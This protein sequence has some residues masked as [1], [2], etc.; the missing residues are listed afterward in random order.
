MTSGFLVLLPPSETK[1]DGG[2]SAFGVDAPGAATGS[3]PV[4]AGSGD[5]AWP[6]LDGIRSDLIDDLAALAHDVSATASALKISPK[7][8]EIEAARNRE[9]R[10]SPRMPAGLRYTGVLYDALDASSLDD[11]SWRWMRR[12]VAVHSALYGLVGAGEPIAAY[13]CSSSSRV[14][15][16]PLKQRWS[17]NIADALAA[18]DGT[19]LDLRSGGYQSLGSAGAKALM[20]DVVTDDGD[21]GVRALNH[22]NKRA[23]GELVRA[24]ATSEIGRSISSSAGGADVVRAMTALGFDAETVSPSRLRL[25]VA[26]PV[27]V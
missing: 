20:L 14:P 7:L 2:S 11:E 23:K 1:R 25:R 18:H 10:T 17:R 24:L 21:G 3:V 27:R 22:F 15:S 9:L 5:L 19:I 12:H 4:H 13:R 26:D 16:P 6:Q 8:A